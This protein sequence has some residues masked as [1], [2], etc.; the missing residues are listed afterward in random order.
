MSID[1]V[2]KMT[3]E[4]FVEV[5]ENGS[6]TFTDKNTG[7][8][9][10]ITREEIGTKY[11]GDPGYLAALELLNNVQKDMHRLYGYE[12][13]D[14]AVKSLEAYKTEIIESNPELDGKSYVGFI[15][16]LD[17]GQVIP[18]F[19]NR[20]FI[21][22]TEEENDYKFI[23]VNSANGKE[24]CI[25]FYFPKSDSEAIII[26]P[27]DFSNIAVFIEENGEIVDVDTGFLDYTNVVKLNYS[28]IYDLL[29]VKKLIIDYLGTR[30]LQLPQCCNEIVEGIKEVQAQVES[31]LY[32]AQRKRLKK[33]EFPELE[34]IQGGTNALVT[35][36]NKGVN[37]EILAMPKLRRIED[38]T[39]TTRYA[40]AFY[41]IPFVELPN[42]VEY[43]GRHSFEANRIVK[44][45][46]RNAIY[47]EEWCT[48]APTQ[49]F[50]IDAFDIESELYLSTAAANWQT[51]QYVDLFKRLHSYAGTPTMKHLYLN[52]TGQA[53]ATGVYCDIPGHESELWEDYLGTIGWTAT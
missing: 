17:D 8:P 44:I 46:S 14:F 9:I 5:L 36:L 39:G 13:T 3:T 12:H 35:F 32:E 53:V 1:A 45:K 23:G 34:I 41:Q 30:T 6:A 31:T 26:E 7:E 49:Q 42:T 24:L 11:L 27:V 18:K 47:H 25:C 37:L 50:I 2:W 16:L 22:G 48:G 29:S 33:A 10:T 52:A 15:A 40:G 43:V 28:S 51:A 21:N 38:T 20:L 19:E 4:Q